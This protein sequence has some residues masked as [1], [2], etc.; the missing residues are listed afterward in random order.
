MMMSER[1]SESNPMNL[2]QQQ[3]VEQ[4]RAELIRF[5]NTQRDD[6]PD[7]THRVAHM[8]HDESIARTGKRSSARSFDWSSLMRTGLATWWE[9][10]PVRAGVL[11]LKS[12]AE[13]AARRR[14]LQAVVIAGAVGVAVVVFRPWRLLSVSALTMSLLRS[15]NFTAMAASFMDTAAQTM[16]K[17]KS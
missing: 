10:H 3:S 8:S 14:P 13:D 15:S 9:D 16:Q 2:K 5:L 4:T 11:L 6:E 7:A 17:E 1:I 12:A